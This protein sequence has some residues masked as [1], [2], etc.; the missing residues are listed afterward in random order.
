MMQSTNNVLHILS[1]SD[2]FVFLIMKSCQAHARTIDFHIG[3][4][5][6]LLPHLAPVHISA[7]EEQYSAWLSALPRTPLTDASNIVKGLEDT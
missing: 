3:Q 6:V 1:L 5:P 7:N 2:R 4:K